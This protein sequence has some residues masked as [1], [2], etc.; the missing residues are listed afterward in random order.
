[1]FVTDVVL[2]VKFYLNRSRFAVVVQNVKGLTFLGTH[3]I[4][5]CFTLSSLPQLTD[6]ILGEL[7]Y[8][9]WHRD[10]PRCADIAILSR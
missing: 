2:S 8:F 4:I 7:E 5:K 3:G 1:M 10:I 9:P 6:V